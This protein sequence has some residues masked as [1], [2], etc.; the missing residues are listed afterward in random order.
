MARSGKRT[1]TVHRF[2]TTNPNKFIK[3]SVGY[4]DGG[5]NYFDNRNSARGFYMN[6]TPI[7]VESFDGHTIEKMLLFHGRRALIKETK[8]YNEKQMVALADQ[9]C[10]ECKQHDPHIMR[11]VNVVLAEEKLTLAQQELAD[12]AN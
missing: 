2:S 4:D 10:E 6:F 12:A 1:I 9:V 3:V 7:E 11:I 5:V 8:R